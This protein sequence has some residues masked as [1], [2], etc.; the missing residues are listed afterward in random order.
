MG[1]AALWIMMNYLMRDPCAKHYLWCR[2]GVWCAR[3]N[4]RDGIS[5]KFAPCRGHRPVVL[6]PSNVQS[7]VDKRNTLN[8][9]CGKRTCRTR[10]FFFFFRLDNWN[11]LTGVWIDFISFLYKWNIFYKK[12]SARRPAEETGC[13]ENGDL[14]QPFSRVIYSQFFHSVF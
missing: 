8:A 3:V 13:R 14:N 4:K 12:I 9:K 5:R 2:R 1:D 7:P 6:Y 10:H 11:L